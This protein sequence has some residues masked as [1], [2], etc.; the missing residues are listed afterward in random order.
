MGFGVVMYTRTLDII[1]QL[2][3]TS[4]YYST[5]YNYS[6]YNHSKS[7]KYSIS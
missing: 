3:D 6:I 5:S 1:I 7:Y 4:Y 2:L